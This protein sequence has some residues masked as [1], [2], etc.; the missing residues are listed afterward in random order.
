MIIYHNTIIAAEP[1]R[2]VAMAALAGTGAG[3]S[4][5]VFN[6]IFYHFGRLPGYVPADAAKDAA[7]DGN[8]YWSPLAS[9]AEA[10]A[11]F[12]RYRAS[13][14]FAD[15][16]KLHAPGSDA[17]SRVADPKFVRI[18]AQAKE[19]GDYRLQRSSPA[20][21]AGVD[22]PAAWP[23]PLRSSD[24]AKPDIGAVPAGGQPFRVGRAAP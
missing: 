23:D 20:M 5:R 8:L 19:A 7:G 11:L 3:N 6:N 9:A 10:G 12:D 21:D 18:S 16:K 14:A 24:A 17:T 15:S 13:P 2:D 1:A 4:R 22:V